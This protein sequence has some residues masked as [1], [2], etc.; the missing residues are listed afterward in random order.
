MVGQ[1]VDR[2]WDGERVQALRRWLK[3]SQTDLAERLGTRQ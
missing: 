3:T 2:G 1:D